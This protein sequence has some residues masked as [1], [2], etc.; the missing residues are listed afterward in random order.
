MFAYLTG[1]VFQK[2]D[3]ALVILVGGLG[4]LVRTPHR[5]AEKFSEGDL[6][7]FHIYTNVREDD[8]SLF[9]FENEEE[10]SLFEKLIS[11]SG[12]GPRLGL[13][14]LEESP[15][16]VQNAIFAGNEVL[17]TGIPGIGKKTAARV[18]LELKSK[19]EPNE[20]FAKKITTQVDSDAVL[21]L[22]GLGYDRQMIVKTLQNLPEGVTEVEEIVKWFFQNG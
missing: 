17:L 16:T 22:E 11:V 18:I 2:K 10:L 6:V 9:G 5:I 21:A 7:K 4:Y 19:I 8:L 20:K 3:H 12:I 1:K 15:H 13:E 14:I